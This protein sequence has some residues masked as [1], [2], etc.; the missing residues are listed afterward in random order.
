MGVIRI[1]WAILAPAVFWLAY[2]YYKDRRQPEPPANLLAAWVLGFLSG[3]LCF[4]FY[5][6]L[7]RAG[8]TPDFRAVLSQTSPMEFFSYLVVFNGLVEEIFKFLPFVLV[9]LRFRAFDEKID[10][11]VYAAALAVGFAS[12]E[13]IGYLPHLRGLAFMGR[14]IASPLT[15][16]VFASIWGYAVGRAFLA[17]RSIVPAAVLGLGLAGL[18]HGLYNFLTFSHAVRVLSAVLILGIWMWVIR[19]LEKRAG[20]VRKP[21]SSPDGEVRP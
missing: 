16:T 13:N 12:F 20:G 15:H 17:R 11:I 1:A 19:T 5:G 18:A 6:V 14:A 8:L 3:F 4:Q 9:V 10:G 21:D 7:S 2:Y